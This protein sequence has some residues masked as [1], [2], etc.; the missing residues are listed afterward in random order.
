MSSDKLSLNSSEVKLTEE[1]LTDKKQ[2]KKFLTAFCDVVLENA[3]DD[4]G[5]IKKKII[6]EYFA[7]M[8]EMIMAV[9]P[10]KEYIREYDK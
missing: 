2:L 10:D 9:S 1:H 4:E 6:S 8:S 3:E 5:N 7:T